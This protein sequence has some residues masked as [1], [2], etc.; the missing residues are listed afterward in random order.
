MSKMKDLSYEIEQLYIEGYSAKT[1]S[2]M[3]ECP[4]EVVYNWVDSNGVADIP[5]LEDAYSEN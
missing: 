1:I 4:V 3:L 2:V 5:Q